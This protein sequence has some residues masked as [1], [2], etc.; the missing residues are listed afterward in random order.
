MVAIIAWAAY[1]T[2][3]EMLPSNTMHKFTRSFIY[4]DTKH[5]YIQH[6]HI[7]HI[8][9]TATEHHF[10]NIRESGGDKSITKQAFVLYL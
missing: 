5:Q 1:K 9:N 10:A 2:R 3:I 6:I 8:Y 7:Q 4:L